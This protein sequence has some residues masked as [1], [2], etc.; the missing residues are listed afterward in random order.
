MNEQK[1]LSHRQ[2]KIGQQIRFLISNFLI[3]EDFVF[4]KFDCKDITV[5]D[6]VI[7]SDLKHAKIYVT[8]N[9]KFENKL[10]IK[11]LNSKASF[12]QHRIASNLSVKFTPKLKFFYDSSFEYSHKINIMNVVSTVNHSSSIL[13]SI[14]I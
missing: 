10:L 13:L 14:L 2:L 12:I 1:Q 9:S 4:E 5:V 7:G 11:E 6:V 8:I 3:K